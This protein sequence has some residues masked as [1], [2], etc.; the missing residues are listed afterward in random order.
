MFRP[1]VNLTTTHN[2]EASFQNHHQQKLS[3][4]KCRPAE[5]K[6]IGNLIDHSEFEN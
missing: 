4:I 3:K 1:Y 6:I 2:Y 5:G